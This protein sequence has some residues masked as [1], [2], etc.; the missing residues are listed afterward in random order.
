MIF[1][2]LF[3]YH[4]H[5]KIADPVF[6][7]PLGYAARQRSLVDKVHHRD[8]V[9][10]P[11]DPKGRK[12]TRR[13]AVGGDDAVYFMVKLLQVHAVLGNKQAEVIVLHVSPKTARRGGCLLKDPADA[14]EHL[15]SFFPAVPFIEKHKVF[16]VD[17]D[18]EPGSGALFKPLLRLSEKISSLKQARHG[19]EPDEFLM[20]PLLQAFVPVYQRL[21]IIYVAPDHTL[22]NA[23]FCPGDH[24]LLYPAPLTH[25]IPYA[26]AQ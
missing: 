9:L 15:V 2:V 11:A 21:Y 7:I 17:R 5:G 19:I 20:P 10:R 23:I 25:F 3:I 16:Q 4:G 18:H 24:K 14:R 22:G 6:V 26:K 8:V 12:E 1:L 13:S